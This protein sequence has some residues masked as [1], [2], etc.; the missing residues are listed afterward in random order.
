MAMIVI[1]L[2]ANLFGAFNVTVPGRIASLGGSG[3]PGHLSTLGMGFM[4]AVLATPFSVAYLAGALAWAQ[5]KPIWLGTTVLLLIGAG[6]AA[7][8]ALLCAFPGL[9]KRLPKPGRWMELFKQSMGFL[10][11]PVALWLLSTLS[12]D[13]YPFLVAGFGVALAFGLWVWGTW[14]RYDAPLGRK[15]LVRGLATALVVG[16]GFVTLPKPDRDDAA[17]FAS[18]DPARLA[19]AREAGHVVVLKF[20]ATWC[21]ECKVIDYTVYR[22]PKV[23]EE[24]RR[25]GVVAIKGDVTDHDTP[26]AELLRNRYGGAP[27]MTVIY[28]PGEGE[29]IVLVGRYGQEDLFRA[30]DAAGG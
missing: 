12:S 22:D 4:M 6:M 3:A 1:A 28:P 27:P 19:S 14:V 23:I 16:V 26:A 30:L 15:L 9:V 21:T 17:V 13:S 18:F 7:P 25:R 29:E 8:H 10:L 11:L 5:A 24:F 20:T 2:S